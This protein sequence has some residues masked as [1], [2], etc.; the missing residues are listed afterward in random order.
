MAI[1]AVRGMKDLLPP[2]APKWRFIEATAREVFG[3]FGFSE[4]RTPIL[5][6]T[7]LFARSIGEETDIVSKEMYTFEDRSGDSL[8]M[9][10]EA[11]AGVV[12]AFLEN[13]L[14]AVPGPHKLCTIGPMFRH[15]RPQKGRL[16]QFHQLD[17]EILD[18]AGP[19]G[20]AELLVMAAHLLERLGVR[21]VTLVLNSLGCPECRPVFKQQ[22][23]DYFAGR[24]GGLCEDCRRRLATNPLRVLDCKQEGCKEISLG[25]P[26]I[27]GSWCESCGEHFD[28][29]KRLLTQSS[30]TFETDPK[31]VRGLD[32]YTRTAFEFKT[33]QLG[34]QDAV[35]GG[36]RYDGLVEALGG[37]ATPAIGFALGV[38][39]LALLLEDRPEWQQ[40]PSLFI[41]ALGDEPRDWAFGAA[42]EL[43]RAGIWV[44]MSA[45]ATS[46]KAQMRRANK[47][48]ASRVL[49]VGG[50]ELKAGIAPLKDMAN[51]EQEDLPLDQIVDRLKAAGA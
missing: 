26:L 16:R 20:D 7:E 12:R 38:E 30:V 24:Q 28:Q 32:Y 1:Q 50:E 42:Q 25:A 23:Q 48:G 10:P 18:D 33:T 17:C 47:L 35:G 5:E 46:L 37:P 34:A 13:K 15:E 29:V 9:R 22:L 19:Q 14:Y 4:I 41:A 44:E 31:L 8:T 27:S 21:Q 39:R 49:I 2:E 3:S 45:A 51:G 11:T 43:R 36:G 40:G 6:R